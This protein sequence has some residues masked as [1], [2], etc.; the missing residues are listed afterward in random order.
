[1]CHRGKIKPANGTSNELISPTER[2]RW[3]VAAECLDSNRT[4][5]SVISRFADDLRTNSIIAALP[6]SLFQSNA[7]AAPTLPPRVSRP[8]YLVRSTTSFRAILQRTFQADGATPT[9]EPRAEEP[10]ACRGIAAPALHAARDLCFPAREAVC[11]PW[12][13]AAYQ[14]AR[15]SLRSLSR[16][17]ADT[18][19][20]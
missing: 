4:A 6:S 16:G 2:I 13:N 19:C 9:A 20:P 3:R 15:P 17:P 10:S 12:N 7:Q 11:G 8:R 18:K 5:Q 14:G 1:T